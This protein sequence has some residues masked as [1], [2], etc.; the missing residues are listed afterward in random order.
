M[1]W[2]SNDGKGPWGGKGDD[3]KFNWQKR[4]STG[5]ASFEEAVRRAQ[6]Q[7]KQKFPNGPSNYFAISSIAAVLFFLWISTGVYMPREGEEAAILRFGEYVRTTG[8]GLSWHIPFPFE[9]AITRRVSEVNQITSDTDSPIQV[10]VG[11]LRENSDQP[12]MLTGDENIVDVSYTVQWYINDLKSY[13]FETKDP[14]ITVKIAAESVIREIIAQTPMTQILTTGRGT[15]SDKAKELLQ[16]LCDEYA[17]GIQIKEV[18]LQRADP[19][20]PVI[21][22]YRSVQRAKALKE[23]KINEATTYRNGVV[24]AAEGEAIRL[25]QKAEGYKEAKVAKANGEAGQ[26][27]LILKEYEKAPEITSSRL[28]IETIQKVLQGA[29]KVFFD[30][31]KGM[32]NV[33]P[34]MSLPALVPQTPKKEGSE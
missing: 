15:I 34:H 10:A 4:K 17:L 14:D 7:F 18:S 3:N 31:E 33:L 24:P 9:Q 30:S 29:P 27:K 16:K 22:S 13:L 20:A 28:R 8:P 19:P 26:F 32:S 12:L 2:D 6:D 21:E 11:T 5:P 25:I 1:A 23:Q